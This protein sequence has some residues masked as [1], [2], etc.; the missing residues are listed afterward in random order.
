MLVV[1]KETDLHI[2]VWIDQVH[3]C[4]RVYGNKNQAIVPHRKI[5]FLDVAVSIKCVIFVPSKQ[6]SIALWECA[7]LLVKSKSIYPEPRV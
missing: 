6:G 7:G 4:L 5:L 1:A 2:K 3:Y